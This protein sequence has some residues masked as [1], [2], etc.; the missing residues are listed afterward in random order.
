MKEFILLIRVPLSYTSEQAA[1][2]NPK[3][4]EVTDKWKADN[5]FVTSFV[6]PGLG[7]AVSGE[8]KTARKEFV[9][10]DQLKMVSTIVLRAENLETAMAYANASP[11]LEYGGSVELREIQ[12]RPAVNN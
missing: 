1:A 8:D 6:F 2:V 4:N 5:V 9:V 3:W 12:A 10:S 7:Y 11:I